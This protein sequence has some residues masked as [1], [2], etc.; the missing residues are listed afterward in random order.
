MR[1][2]GARRR[3]GALVLAS[4]LVGTLV[5]VTAWLARQRYGPLSDDEA[6][7]EVVRFLR[8]TSSWKN[9]ALENLEDLRVTWEPE[10]G[11]PR[12]G[13]AVV[14][15]L[16]HRRPFGKVKVYRGLTGPYSEI[17]IDLDRDLSLEADR[18][19]LGSGDFVVTSHKSGS[20]RR[21]EES[22]ERVVAVDLWSRAYP[23]SSERVGVESIHL[24]YRGPDR[25]PPFKVVSTEVK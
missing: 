17:S 13:G 11:L 22:P 20:I 1:P 8:E 14:E 4:L 21:F 19:G 24:S 12:G 6:K 10:K 2:S 18:L 5:S 15:G 16:C 25:P 9:L 23:G 3:R 7:E